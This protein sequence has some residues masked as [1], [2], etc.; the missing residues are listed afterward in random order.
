MMKTQAGSQGIHPSANNQKSNRV[1]ISFT[2]ARG[3]DDNQ[4]M[5]VFNVHDTVVRFV[6]TPATELGVIIA[7]LAA[8]YN[9]HKRVGGGHT[10]EDLANTMKKYF[11]NLAMVAEC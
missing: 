2:G 7:H 5:T 11:T 8:K 3:L 1:E 6:G 4:F 10:I 9:D